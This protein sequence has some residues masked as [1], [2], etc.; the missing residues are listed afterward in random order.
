MVIYLIYKDAIPLESTKLQKPNDHVLNICEDVP[1]GALQPDPNQVVKS[2]APA[3]AVI[4]DEDPNN[5]K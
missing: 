4:G 1:N 2:G 3:V 5:G